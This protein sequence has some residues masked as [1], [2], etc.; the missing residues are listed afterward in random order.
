[1]SKGRVTAHEV[2]ATLFAETRMGQRGYRASEVDAFLDRVAITIASLDEQLGAAKTEIDRLRHWRQQ[3]GIGEDGQRLVNPDDVLAYMNTQLE[4][5]QLIARA[6][7]EAELI[8]LQARQVAEQW[9]NALNWDT[10]ARETTG[11]VSGQLRA[12][13]AVLAE[14]AD[15]LAALH[16]PA[17]QEQYGPVYGPNP[18]ESGIFPV[19]AYDQSE[20]DLR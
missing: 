14:Q 4:C 18:Y 5:E 19:P 9:T 12:L 8:E 6:E 3:R 11:E 2:R 16:D 15:T 1:M 7:R 20:P 17:P 13:A 10:M